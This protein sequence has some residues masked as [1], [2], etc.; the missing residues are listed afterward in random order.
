MA[1]HNA[2]VAEMFRE[3]ADLLEIEGANPFRVRAYRNAAY[4]I[5]DLGQNVGDLVE[6]GA[7]LTEL[8]GVGKDLAAAIE[9]IVETGVY[10]E[11]DEV[12]GR[13]DPT[14]RD[15]LRIPGLGP[16]RIQQLHRELGIRSV[17]DLEEALEAGRLESL[18]GF[19]K[20]TVENIQKALTAGR[21]KKERRR[22]STVESI[23]ESLGDFL[24]DIEGVERAEI[25]GSYRR[26]RDTVA[27]LDSVASS[28][29]PES[30]IDA[31]VEYGEITDVMSHGDTRASV[32]LRSGLSV[33]LRVVQ[34]E[35]YGAAL[36]Y[37]T[38]SRNHQLQLRDMAIDRGWKLNEYGIFDGDEMIAGE[39]EA[40][41]Y[42]KLD[43]PYIEPELREQRGEIEAAQKGE[44]PDLIEVDDLKGDL[45]SH[46]NWTDGR[47]TIEEMA[48]TALEHGHSYLAITDHSKR[49]RMVRGLD[50]DDLKRQSE[51]I[52]KVAESLDS[53]TLLKGVEVDILDDGTLDLPDEALA[54]LDIV[55]CSVHNKLGMSYEKQTERILRAIENPYCMI[56]GHPTG[57]LLGS[58]DPMDFDM[59]KVIRAAK[60]AGCA[61]EINA[62]PNR[63]DLNDR[64]VKLGR[65]IGAKFAINTDAH[66]QGGLANLRYGIAQARRGWLSAG[67]VLNTRSLTELRKLLRRP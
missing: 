63:L 46:T 48:R 41:V 17:Q 35:S 34:P 6:E 10:A 54:E 45:H 64:N 65:D 37:F 59:E 14:L 23:A 7:D 67:D 11:L 5:D 2:D 22:R 28:T 40:D 12:R 15:L 16:K 57:R 39:T 62:D 25:A 13:N 27:D 24:R 29:D 26:W 38:G 50:V 66:G 49:M 36:L 47:G 52:D 32:F 3:M 30:V 33:D 20:K 31:F 55:I 44:L 1:I 56:L 21:R 58:R 9:E 60:D 42:A 18:E 61:L 43:L 8:R 53:I 19:G 51:E 4:T